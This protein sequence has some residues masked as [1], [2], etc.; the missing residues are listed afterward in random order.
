LMLDDIVA[1]LLLYIQFKNWKMSACYD[2]Y[3]KRSIAKLIT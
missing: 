2:S 1:K 3:E